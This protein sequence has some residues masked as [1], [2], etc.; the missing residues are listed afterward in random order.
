[1]Q[2]KFASIIIS[3]ESLGDNWEAFI[4][5]MSDFSPLYS[6]KEKEKSFRFFFG[7][8]YWQKTTFDLPII[9]EKTDIALV[10]YCYTLSFYK[11]Q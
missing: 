11:N 1:M 2:L 10:I 8:Y 7:L 3:K 9:R 5:G 4:C 6:L